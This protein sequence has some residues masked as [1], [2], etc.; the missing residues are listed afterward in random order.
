MN[1][2]LSVVALA[3]IGFL[4]MGPASAE[5]LPGTIS[6]TVVNPVTVSEQQAVAL[7]AVLRSASPNVVTL[8][9]NGQLGDAADS[10]TTNGRQA[11]V[12]RVTGTP[13]VLVDITPDTAGGGNCSGGISLANLSTSP[14]T[15]EFMPATGI[16]DISIG[17]TVLIPANAEGGHNCSYTLTVDYN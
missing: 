9:T 6:M 13:S 3:G 7:G 15:L 10:V 5:T 16:L 1:K 8:G 12:M 17:A 2:C 11:G 14:S 4:G